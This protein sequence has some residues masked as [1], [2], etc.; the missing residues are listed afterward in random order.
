M[1]HVT[2]YMEWKHRKEIPSQQILLLIELVNMR[3]VAWEGVE[4]LAG[5]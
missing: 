1:V 2:I 4:V 3:I 5:R